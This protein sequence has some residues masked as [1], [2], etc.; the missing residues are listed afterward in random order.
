MW[1]RA[2]TGSMAMFDIGPPIRIE[3]ENGYVESRPH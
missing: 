1:R 3:D 2:S